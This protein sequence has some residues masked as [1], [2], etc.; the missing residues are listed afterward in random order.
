MKL[1]AKKYLF[2]MREASLLVREFAQ[3]NTLD[4]FRN[5][6][7]PKSAI[8]RQLF[9]IGE[10]LQ[11]LDKRYPDVANRIPNHRS[12]INFR[13]ILAHGYNRVEDEVTWGIVENEISPLLNELEK[14]L[15]EPED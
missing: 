11:Q 8:E 12:I 6:V 2:D 9:I 15:N 4:S 14:L 7:M 5:D 1:E 10:A 13:H 3:D